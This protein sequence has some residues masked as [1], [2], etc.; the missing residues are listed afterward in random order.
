MTNSI[1]TLRLLAFTE[2]LSLLT[3]LFIAMPLKY[4]F[5]MPAAVSLV[6]WVHGVLFMIFLGFLMF[7]SQKKAWPERF[8]FLVV[9]S[10]MVPFGMVAMDRKLRALR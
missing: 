6:G 2:G 7:I 9:L 4:R 1:N 3:L 8:M 10:S 5:E